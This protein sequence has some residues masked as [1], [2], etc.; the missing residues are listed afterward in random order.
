MPSFPVLLPEATPDD[1]VPRYSNPVLPGD[2][3]DP[4][5]D[6]RRP[7]LLG[8]GHLPRAGGRRSRCSTSRDLVDWV[9]VGSV[10][11]QAAAL[12][13]GA[14]SGPRRSCKRGRGYLV[15]Y[16]A[17]R[18]AGRFCIGEDVGRDSARAFFRDRGPVNGDPPRGDRP[19]AGD[20]TSAAGP[21]SSGRS[22]ATRRR[23]HA[24][25]GR[26]AHEG[27]TGGLPGR[28]ASC[29]ATTGPG[30]GA[31]GGGPG[32]D[33]H[34]AAGSTC[35]IPPAAAAGSA[36]DYVMGVARAMTLLGAVGEAQQA[37]P[38]GQPTLPLPGARHR[39]GRP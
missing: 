6:P 5:V 37:V 2:Y 8:R 25:P 19:A 23:A 11:Q 16:S 34:T 21:T 35:S 33:P 17:R 12:G 3:P 32:A 26:A 39:G 24:D 28:R 13:P 36:C 29:S 14:T 4:S 15:Y 18:P 9:V 10:L 31:R 1:G 27:R 30:R 20:G 7:G 22:T 38:E